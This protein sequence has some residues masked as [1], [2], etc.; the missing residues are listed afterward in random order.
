MGNHFYKYYL[1]KSLFKIAV[2]LSLI[3]LRM[4]KSDSK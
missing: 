2:V 3:Q 1:K 4:D